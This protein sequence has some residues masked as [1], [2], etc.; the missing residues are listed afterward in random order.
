MTP[1][2]RRV[3]LRVG[4]VSIALAAPLCGC[5]GSLPPLEGTRWVLRDAWESGSHI[6]LE[7]KTEVWFRL[8]RGRFSAGDGCNWGSSSY[9]LEGSRVDPGPM[10][11]TMIACSEE[12]FH[13]AHFSKSFA[14][15]F[16][17]SQLEV[18][19][20]RAEYTYSAH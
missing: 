4:L 1:N 14:C 16:N 5:A 3:E 19:C 2:V 10:M 20:D 9:E 13:P 7:G 8:E 17:G 6:D 15:R 11:S 18:V 12:T